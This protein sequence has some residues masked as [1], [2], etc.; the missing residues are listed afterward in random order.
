M[1]LQ[2]PPVV[3]V[4]GPQISSPLSRAVER[5]GQFPGVYQ[6]G[7]ATELL[8][9]TADLPDGKLVYLVSP[10]V[11][12]DIDGI[13]LE[14]IAAQIQSQGHFVMAV[15]GSPEGEA[16]GAEA[17]LPVLQPRVNLVQAIAPVCGITPPPA[18]AAR[19]TPAAAPP[20][21]PPTPEPPREDVS[22]TLR[23]SQVWREAHEERETRGSVELAPR[24][25]SQLLWNSA[26]DESRRR[27]I[28]QTGFQRRGFVIAFA[29]RKGGVG[30]T[31]LSVNS[32]AFLGS[33]L[34]AAGKRVVL[35]DMNLQQSDV[36][37]YLHRSTPNIHDLVRNPNLLTSN[38]IEEALAYSEK[39]NIHAL[40]G[41]PAVKDARPDVIHHDMFK[42]I[43]DLLRNQ[44]D[45][46][47]VD[48][49]VG[50]F[51]HDMLR[52]V[53]P[54]ANYI[55]TP[56][57]PARVTLDDIEAWLNNI[58]APRHANGYGIDARK[59]GLVLNRAKLNIGLDPADVED[60]LSGWK[61]IGM[62]P[63]SDEW[64][65]AENTGGLIGAN[66]PR[67]LADVF[68][69]MLYEATYDKDILDSAPS[70]AP[71]GSRSERRKRR[72]WLRRLLS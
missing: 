50:E 24:P 5:T 20:P 6:A 3:I 57:H 61:F 72:G 39:H 18:P 34:A 69:H 21:P 45:Y 67:E 42:Q 35:V 28:H 8:E 33:R 63:D 49:P 48:T 32:A 47:L 2:L 51:Y 37:N 43:L 60:R 40:L 64:Q 52:M 41:P 55:I 36:G 66:P 19:P 56:L 58:T 17:G 59:I 16:F 13:D 44:F 26:L 29:A 38:R 23:R 10:T 1:A 46:I 4:A 54:E 12:V 7:T 71:L 11:D 62:F 31:T 27:G 9:L 65:L 14:S 15:G 68:R 70:A 25:D 53:L 30:K 22:Q